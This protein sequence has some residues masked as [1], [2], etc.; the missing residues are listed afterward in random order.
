MK[1]SEL[2]AFIEQK[3]PEAAR[4]DMPRLVRYLHS[5]LNASVS[6]G[7]RIELRN[8]GVFKTTT[9]LN[10][11]YWAKTPKEY[12]RLCFRKSEALRRAYK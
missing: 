9:Y 4:Y 12:K 3:V 2:I 11:G 7:E 8:L 6:S 10:H 5:F 1:T